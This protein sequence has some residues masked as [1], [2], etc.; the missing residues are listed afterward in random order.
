MSC[1]NEMLQT[2][3]V[4]IGTAL[5]A[6]TERFDCSRILL[7]SLKQAQLQYVVLGSDI[8]TLALLVTL[9]TQNDWHTLT[10]H[11]IIINNSKHMHSCLRFHNCLSSH[12]RSRLLL[13]LCVSLFHTVSQLSLRSMF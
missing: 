13:S 8:H 7:G 12:H 1:T 10:G 2:A 9:N 11:H 5:C 4:L 6:G 3:T